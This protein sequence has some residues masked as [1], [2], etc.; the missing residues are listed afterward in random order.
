MGSFSLI[1]PDKLDSGTKHVQMAGK[2][3]KKRSRSDKVGRLK[4]NQFLLKT[5][6]RQNDQILAEFRWVRHRLE[7]IGEA[8]YERERAY[9]LRFLPLGNSFLSWNTMLGSGA[10]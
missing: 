2:P 1:E 3:R 10:V 8:D 6:K 4:Y 7:R 5:V 9:S